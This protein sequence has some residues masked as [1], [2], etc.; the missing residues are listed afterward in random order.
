MS[1]LLDRTADRTSCSLQK[2]FQIPENLDIFMISF[3]TFCLWDTLLATFARVE[4]PLFVSQCVSCQTENFILDPHS[5]QKEH[6]LL[7]FTQLFTT[8][9]VYNCIKIKQN[10]DWRPRGKLFLKQS[11]FLNGKKW[12]IGSLAKHKNNCDFF[13]WSSTSSSAIFHKHYKRSLWLVWI[14]KVLE[15]LLIAAGIRE[16]ISAA[17]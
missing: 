12:H 2:A 1:F 3:V 17:L 7:P 13:R 10:Q 16:E 8:L 15:Y 5:G 4:P 14:Y 9:F 11:K 6:K